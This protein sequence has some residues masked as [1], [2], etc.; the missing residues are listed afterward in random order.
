MEKSENKAIQI[1]KLSDRLQ[2]FYTKIRF[3]KILLKYLEFA[4]LNKYALDISH[5]KHRKL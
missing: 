4:V 2:E 3:R 1:I 5:K